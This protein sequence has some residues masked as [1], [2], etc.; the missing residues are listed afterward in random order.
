MTRYTIGPRSLR[1]VCPNLTK[2]EAEDLARALGNAFQRYGITNR[3]RAA[4]AVA[5][6]AHECDRFRTSEEYATG[7]SYE[8]RRDLGN[9]LPGDGTR[10]KGRGFIQ[11]TCRA[12]YRAVSRALGVNFERYPRRLGWFKY[13]ALASCWWWRSHG[14]NQLADSGDFVALTRRINGGTNGLADR[15]ALHR[16]ARRV[17]RWL[18]PRP[19]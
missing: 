11:I 14:C 13:A 10:Y 4:A 6:M 5:Q 19:V 12:N 7:A 18:V 8:G 1:Y 9:V 2:G 16:R 15:Q 3:R 17:S